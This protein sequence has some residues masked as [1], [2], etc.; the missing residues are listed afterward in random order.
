MLFDLTDLQAGDEIELPP[1]IV[2]QYI[3]EILAVGG[4]FEIDGNIVRILSL[5]KIVSKESK[6][7]K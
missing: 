3:S 6:V 1:I 5:P 4:S 7:K 2:G